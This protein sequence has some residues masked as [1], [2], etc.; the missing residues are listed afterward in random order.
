MRMTS[1]P[2]SASIMPQKG[3]GPMPCSSMTLR[4]V[5]GPMCFSLWLERPRHARF[6]YGEVI[7][8]LRNSGGGAAPLVHRFSHGG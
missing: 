1:A 3:P 5:S 4:P 8:L 7:E 2:M 6:A